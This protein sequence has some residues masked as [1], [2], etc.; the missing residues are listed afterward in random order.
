MK[1]SPSL[2]MEP[3]ALF[4]NALVWNAQ[5]AALRVSCNGTGN[6]RKAKRRKN[7]DIVLGGIIIVVSDSLSSCEGLACE[8]GGQ[9]RK[10]S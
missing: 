8:V 2:K 5:V 1:A 4:P 9:R 3:T 10:F 7:R 6:W